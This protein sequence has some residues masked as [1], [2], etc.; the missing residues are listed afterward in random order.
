[1]HGCGLDPDEPQGT[2]IRRGAGTGAAGDNR[3]HGGAGVET[4]AVLFG[5]DRDRRIAVRRHDLCGTDDA[6]EIFAAGETVGGIVGA[7]AGR[8]LQFHFQSARKRE[9]HEP[10]EQDREHGSDQQQLHGCD[11]A[12]SPSHARCLTVSAT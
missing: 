10:E 6:W 1:M 5:G 8:C 4:A 9:R 2:R 11:A 12:Y 7:G 3:Q